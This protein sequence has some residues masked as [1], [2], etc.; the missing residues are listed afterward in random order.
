MKQKF[1]ISLGRLFSEGLKVFVL[2]EPIPKASEQILSKIAL[3]CA[4]V[5]F[6][7]LDSNRIRKRIHNII[8]GRML[9]VVLLSLAKCCIVRSY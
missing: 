5:Q 1:K 7:L 9:E 8:I 6:N 4:S 2:Q 3:S